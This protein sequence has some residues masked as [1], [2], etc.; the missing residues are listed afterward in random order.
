MAN[1]DEV[2]VK[3]GV[4]GSGVDSGMQEAAQGVSDGAT[5]MESALSSLTESFEKVFDAAKS[6]NLNELLESFG[7]IKSSAL[8]AGA[9]IVELGE[10]I[11]ECVDKTFELNEAAADMSRAFGMS[12]TDAGVLQAQTQLAGVSTSTYTSALSMLNRQVRNN[13]ESLNDMGLATRDSSGEFL[14]SQQLMQN[15]ISLMNEYEAGTDRVQAA[16]IMFGRG[17]AESAQLLKLLNEPMQDARDTVEAYG[18]TITEQSQASQEAFEKSMNSSKLAITGFEN[19]VGSELMPVFTMMLQAFN[20]LAPAAIL[21]LKGAF[22]GLA[23]AIELLINGFSTIFWSLNALVDLIGGS[24]MTAWK[25]LGQSMTGDFSG[26]AATIKAGASEI[27]ASFQQSFDKIAA[28]SAKTAEQIAA[29]FAE[30]TPTGKPEGGTKKAPPK[31]DSGAA[32]LQMKEWQQEIQNRLATEQIFGEQA[33][34]LE[35]A[36]WQSKLEIVKAGTDEYSQIQGRVYAIEN[37]NSAKAAEE[38]KKAQAEK[39]ATIMDGYKQQEIAAGKNW[40]TV[41][42]IEQSALAKA[43]ELYGVDSQ[44]YRKAA[45]SIVQTEQKK[46]QELRALKEGQ[47]AYSQSAA[48]ADVAFDEQMAK[49]AEQAGQISKAQLLQQEAEFEQRKFDIQNQAL[50]DQKSLQDQD[51][52]HDPVK[53]Q[54]TNQQIE[55]LARRHVQ[56]MKA[57]EQQASN[58]GG[59]PF[60]QML[61]HMSSQWTSGLAKMMQGT[62]SFSKFMKGMWNSIV[63]GFTEMVAELIVKWALKEAMNTA[64]TAEGEAERIALKMWGATESLAITAAEAIKEIA[65]RAYQAIA[66]AW[67]AISAIPYVGPFLA[68]AVA[69]AT[70]AA[71]FAIGSSISS[72]EGG[73]DI[74]PGSNPMT[75]L[76]A[77][78]MVLPAPIAQTVRTAMANMGG[79][80]SGGMSGGF[81]YHDHSGKATPQTI[82]QNAESWAANGKRAM[83]N[84]NFKPG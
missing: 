36:Y 77:N 66:G 12:A 74:G 32:A 51:P 84:F 53:Y 16:Q 52:N 57:I 55:A 11:E 25:A 9:A 61:S 19:A 23:S 47:I 45:D 42:G 4:E 82:Q 70:G 26:A 43:A 37:A 40:D 48:L 29:N 62:L 33:K 81:H 59:A 8:L 79:S 56:N 15:A 10:K 39:N 83:R 63:S 64:A 78:E 1:D 38:A 60:T 73:F 5:Q 24:V 28:N 7:S 49:M 54:Q 2:K 21:I 44:Q 72:A 67:A 46:Q 30:G 75:Q 58:E 41:L 35:L 50:Q 27:E 18:L 76:H 65:I 22:A 69:L 14:S 20:T 6:G 34:Q 68:P 80:G 13:E 17:A 71:I 31:D 3:V